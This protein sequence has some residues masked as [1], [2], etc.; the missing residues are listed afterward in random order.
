MNHK[1]IFFCTLSFFLFC[2]PKISLPN[3][4]GKDYEKFH[5]LDVEYHSQI[6]ALTVLKDVVVGGNV[7]IA[8]LVSGFPGIAPKVATLTKT[9]ATLASASD[10]VSFV[11]PAND[12]FPSVTISNGTTTLI[13]N[14]AHNAA[15][16]I[17][18]LNFPSNPNHG[19]KLTIANDS[20][21]NTIRLLTITNWNASPNSIVGT[22]TTL[23]NYGTT[24][25]FIFHAPTKTWYRV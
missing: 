20:A 2:I 10:G 5:R 15:T 6:G 3:R 18:V 12:I 7:T 19:Q 1:K 17:T 11:T 24:V 13:V 9:G 25:N 4:H 8:G 14:I 22:F 21:L 23:N 16:T